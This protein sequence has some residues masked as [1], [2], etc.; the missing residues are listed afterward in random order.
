MKKLL[1]LVFSLSISAS[2][3]AAVP[4]YVANT[5][6]SSDTSGKSNN[7]HGNNVD[8]VDSSNPGQGKGGPNGE[9]DP[10]GTVDDE[11]KTTTADSSTTT[12][13]AKDTTTTTT[14]TGDN[15]SKSKDTRNN[16]NNK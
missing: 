6:T 13:D 10:S 14:T 5:N 8:G 4:G 12:T 15:T 2:V 3:F 9:A 7:G 16:G 1:V 11:K